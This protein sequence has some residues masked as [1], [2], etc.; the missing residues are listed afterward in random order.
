MKPDQISDIA[1][2]Y[3][4]L[5]LFSPLEW[6]RR[7]SWTHFN[8]SVFHQLHQLHL[9]QLLCVFK[10]LLHFLSLKWTDDQ[11]EQQEVISSENICGAEVLREISGKL[12]TKDKFL[13]TPFKEFLALLTKADIIVF[14]I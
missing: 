14:Y 11:R 12:F 1:S 2:F 7:N 4:K 13:R 10:L 5:L 3:H 9:L 8:I 6:Q